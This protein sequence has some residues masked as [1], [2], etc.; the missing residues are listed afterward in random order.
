M[1]LYA[2]GA[3]FQY[4]ALLGQMMLLA[5]LEMQDLMLYHEQQ[6][7]ANEGPKAHRMAHVFMGFVH[8]SVIL[9]FGLAIVD[10][11]ASDVPPVEL[12]VP[13]V[14]A[15]MPATVHLLEGVLVYSYRAW[16]RLRGQPSDYTRVAAINIPE[17]RPFG[18]VL[19][20]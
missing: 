3:F 17:M 10:L 6:H 2:S 19:Y 15:A 8:L 14:F 16:L 20:D 11:F 5:L 7:R 9:S 12:V 13:Q 1:F 18:S 4:V